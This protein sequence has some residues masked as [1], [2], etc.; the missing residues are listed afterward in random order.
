MPAWAPLR[1]IAGTP[2][3]WSAIETRVALWCSPV[4]RRTSS[5]RGSGSSVTAA[6]S[7]EQLVRR[8]AHRRHDDDQLRPARALAHDPPRDPLDSLGARDGRAAEL[9]HD[10]G[11]GHAPHSSGGSRPADPPI[12]ARAGP[13][14][15]S[16]L[17]PLV[18]R[19]R[20]PSTA[21]QLLKVRH[22]QQVRVTARVADRSDRPVAGTGVHGAGLARGSC[23]ASMERASGNFASLCR[24]ATGGDPHTVTPDAHSVHAT[25]HLTR[26]RSRERPGSAGSAS[27]R[28]TSRVPAGRT[29]CRTGVRGPPR[30]AGSFACSTG[31][32]SVQREPE[33]HPRSRAIACAEACLP[34]KPAEHR[35]HVR[36]N[37]L[38]LD[39]DERS[40]RWVEG[41]DVD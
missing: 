4:A 23:P 3:E 2:S 14:S 34:V 9:H 30:G 41:E 11:S 35:L 12:P 10:E 31:Q 28:R 27:H 19:V 17:P 6:A 21:C 15:L 37:G 24:T 33:F 5:S 26:T 25:R 13:S 7:D 39:H 32:G 36:G 8:V 38:H 18:A 1:L 20:W 40:M 16:P 22:C 29:A